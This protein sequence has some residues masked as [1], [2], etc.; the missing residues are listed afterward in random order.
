MSIGGWGGQKKK[1]F[2]IR[3]NSNQNGGN[4][5]KFRKKERKKERKHCQPRI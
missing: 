2:L 4:S 3:K 1:I 5:V